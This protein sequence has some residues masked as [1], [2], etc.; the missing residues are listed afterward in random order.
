MMDK[1]ELTREE[2]EELKDTIT[3]RTKTTLAL[4]SLNK[5]ITEIS[6]QYKKMPI[7]ETHQKI[8]Y[9]LIVLIFGSI[10]TLA[11]RVMAK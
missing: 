6:E 7:I 8:Q 9:T 2:L 10:I 11:F 3:F 5:K 1:I 4:K